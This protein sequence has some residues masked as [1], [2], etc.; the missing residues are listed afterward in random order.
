MGFDEKMPEGMK[1]H[2]SKW[3]RF[4]S[5]T[6]DCVGAFSL[7]Q[8]DIIS[9]SNNSHFC[10]RRPS[11]F[12]T[13]FWM[14]ILWI[15]CESRITNGFLITFKITISTAKPAL[16]Y[17]WRNFSLCL[18]DPSKHSV[19]LFSYRCVFLSAG[20]ERMVFFLFLCCESPIYLPF[21]LHHLWQGNKKALGNK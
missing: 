3:Q 9:S 18:N 1:A 13:G 10:S 14:T 16:F 17:S 6:G 4:S 15:T 7:G 19:L 5:Q 12:L 21:L 2:L 8:F 11:W 20:D